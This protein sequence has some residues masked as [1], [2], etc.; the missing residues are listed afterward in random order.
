MTESI[1]LTWE[2]MNHTAMNNLYLE[3][4]RGDVEMSLH[5]RLTLENLL[6]ETYPNRVDD[7]IIRNYWW[8]EFHKLPGWFGF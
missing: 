4:E 2:D 8:E 6:V 1:I 3:I 7:E 5:F